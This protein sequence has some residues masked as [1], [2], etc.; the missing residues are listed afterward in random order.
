MRLSNNIHNICELEG[1]QLVQEWK[2]EQK[3]PVKV[4]PSQPAK[5]AEEPKKEEK[6]EGGADAPADEKK[7]EKMPDAA[8]PEKKPEEKQPE[9]QYEIKIRER[10][11]YGDIKY[12][13]S[14]FALT[15]SI[16]R[17]FQELENQMF[18]AD[19][20][21]LQLKAIKNDLEAYCYKMKDICGSYGTHEKYI[22]PAVKD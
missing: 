9:Q 22:D 2:E 12:S 3:I 14:S 21:I 4:A 13:T 16:K 19:M 7:D 17:T 6:P 1:A 5:P 15:P 8:E 18:Q 20:D 10:K 11:S